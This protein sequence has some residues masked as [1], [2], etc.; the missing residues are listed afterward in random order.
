MTFNLL[1]DAFYN[2]LD[3]DEEE[4]EVKAVGRGRNSS[5]LDNRF[6]KVIKVDIVVF[7]K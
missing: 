3:E 2:N 1:Y 7:N 5:Q 4:E 6:N